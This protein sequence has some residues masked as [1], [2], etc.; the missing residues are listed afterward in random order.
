MCQPRNVLQPQSLVSV[1]R[2]E[3]AT[4]GSGS[5]LGRGEKLYALYRVISSGESRGCLGA[6]ATSEIDDRDASVAGGLAVAPR[7]GSGDIA[8]LGAHDEL[9]GAEIHVAISH[10][11]LHPVS[12]WAESPRADDVGRMSRISEI[13]GQ[14]AVD[15]PSRRV[16]QRLRVA[17]MDDH[18]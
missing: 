8:V 3:P 6:L 1:R 4:G 7:V 11:G 10:L 12:Y 9:A 18:P 15:F 5:F 14:A 2:H 16:E 13:D 17:A